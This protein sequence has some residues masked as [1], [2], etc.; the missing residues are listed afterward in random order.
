MKLIESI[1]SSNVLISTGTGGVGKTTISCAMAIAIAHA[2]NA[3]VLVITIDPAKRLGSIL[4]E[5]ELGH[6]PVKIEHSH[7]FDSKI[8]VKGELY[9]VTIDMSKG[10]N[11]LVERFSEKQEDAE[12]IFENN[13]YQ[14]LTTRFTHSHDFIAMDQLY[15]YYYKGEYDYIILDTPPM[16]QAFD[17]FDAPKIISD[18]FGGRILNLVTSP[19]RLSQSSK[20]AKLFDL[21]SKPFFTLA[22]KVLG[23]NFLNDI[24]EFFYLFKKIHDPLLK[25]ANDITKFLK[26]DSLS[27]AL[28]MSPTQYLEKNYEHVVEELDAR[29]MSLSNMV[30]NM[31]PFSQQDLVEVENFLDSK[32]STALEKN[33]ID[34][35]CSEVEMAKQIDAKVRNRGLSFGSGDF[36]VKDDQLEVFLIPKSFDVDLTKRLAYLVSVV[37]DS[38]SAS[39]E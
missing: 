2:K 33:Y 10:W 18:F 38:M 17:F 15:Q 6:D 29:S 34:Y 3:K 37:L 23:E 26:S 19:Y 8:D 39:N 36:N 12:K 27:C 32:K 28:I 22:N 11:Q 5:N 24:G 30:I 14:N 20:G 35:L 16:S 31:Y 25:R 13:M 21:A 1:S 4:V 9:G 7:F